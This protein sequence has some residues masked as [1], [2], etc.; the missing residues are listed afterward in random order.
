[1]AAGLEAALDGT[2][3]A[4]D[5]GMG[6]GEELVLGAAVDRVGVAASRGRSAKT[7]WAAKSAGLSKAP[8]SPASY[9]FQTAGLMAAT[10]RTPGSWAWE[11]SS[12]EP[13]PPSRGRRGRCRPRSK[14]WPPRRGT[15]SF[16]S[17]DWVSLP[18]RAACR[19][20][21]PPSTAAMANGCPARDEVP[22][23]DVLGARGRRRWTLWLPPRPWR[24][25]ATG[26]SAARPPGR[27]RGGDRPVR[28]RLRTEGRDEGPGTDRCDR[29]RRD[30]GEPANGRR[31]GGMPSSGRRRGGWPGR[32]PRC[33]RASPAAPRPGTQAAQRAPASEHDSSMP[34]HRHGG[35]WRY[36]G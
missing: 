30:R 6:R 36:T 28:A 35:P 22:L 26:A 14:P 25:S 31:C 8:S 10:A 3:Q 2:W 21:S 18:S 34:D 17:I 4:A 12:R 27:S 7:S 11:A 33:G 1:M 13:K 16:T 20:V 32:L 5:V 24:N 29:R 23:Q 19:Q 15:N 9:R